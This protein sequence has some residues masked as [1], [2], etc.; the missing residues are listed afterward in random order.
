MKLINRMN[1][2]TMRLL[3]LVL[4]FAIPFF[5]PMTVNA[6]NGDNSEAIIEKVRNE[7]SFYNQI[8]DGEIVI[9]I[10]DSHIT[11][12]FIAKICSMNEH[13]L[14]DYIGSL[15]A[16]PTR[17]GGATDNISRLSLKPQLNEA[18]IN[19]NDS[20]WSE[21]K[22][23]KKKCSVNSSIPSIGICQINIPYTATMKKMASTGSWYIDSIE[24]GTSEQTGF[25]VASWSHGD[26]TVEIKGYETYAD[27]VVTGVLTYSIKE[28]PFLYQTEQSFTY[29]LR[30][31]EIMQ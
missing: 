22:V 16:Q 8:Y 7:V 19:A 4:S 10:D 18:F 27:I 17:V 23:V 14:H 25:S 6:S 28:T 11:E 21:Y 13:E 24:I 5:Y 12:E 31:T 1:K 15:Y 29:L 2:Y 30:N 26:A 20:D 3:V 9:S